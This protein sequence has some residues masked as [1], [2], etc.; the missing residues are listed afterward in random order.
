[1][2]LNRCPAESDLLQLVRSA[3]PSQ[4][5]LAL[6]GRH[7]AGCDQCQEKVGHLRQSIASLASSRGAEL[8][9]GSDC[10][11]ADT[12]AA[13]ADGS[14]PPDERSAAVAHLAV[15]GHCRVELAAVC[16]ALHDPAIDGAI[17]PARPRIG[18]VRAQVAG[19]SLLACAAAAILIVAVRRPN[20][21]TTPQLRDDA[22]PAVAPMALTPTGRIPALS[23]FRWSRVSGADLYHVTVFTNDGTIAWEAETSDTTIAAPATAGLRPDVDYF[24]KVDARTEFDRWSGSRMMEFHLTSGRPR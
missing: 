4:G 5:D 11:E 3:K 9:G 24:W 12:V 21:E 16:S 14:L 1:M 10:L 23:P 6:I 15:C 13:L 17:R 20:Q 8:E 22:L 2:M 7:V 19:L 18:P